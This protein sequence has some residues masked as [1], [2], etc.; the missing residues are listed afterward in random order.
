MKTAADLLLILLLSLTLAGHGDRPE[1]G[2]AFDGEV[3]AYEGVTMSVVEGTAAPDSIT[4][5][6]INTTDKEINSGNTGDFAVQIEQDGG[7]YWLKTLQDEYANTA[8]AYRYRT[9]VPK[10]LELDWTQFYGSL[11]SGH[12][13]VVKPFSEY[14]GPGDSTHFLLAAEF[15]LE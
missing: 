15:S 8:E 10:Q 13:R 9:N 3:N 2:N 6:V 7:W 12:Y 11:E 5:E 1:V 14:R 4:V